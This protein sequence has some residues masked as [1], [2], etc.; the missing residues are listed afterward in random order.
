M[1][2]EH[3]CDVLWQKSLWVPENNVYLTLQFKELKDS[4][5]EMKHDMSSENYLQRITMH[6][7]WTWFYGVRCLFKFHCLVSLNFLTV[8]HQVYCPSPHSYF[9]H[10]TWLNCFLILLQHMNQPHFKCVL[11]QSVLA[12]WQVMCSHSIMRLIHHSSHT[13]HLLSTCSSSEPYRHFCLSRTFCLCLAHFKNIMEKSISLLPILEC[14]NHLATWH[15]RP[16]RTF[17][18]QLPLPSHYNTIIISVFICY[19][20]CFCIFISCA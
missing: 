10:F 17:V 4:V 15:L 20:S 1:A 6:L 12:V 13:V 9:L 18:Y 3:L 11:L 5:T 19:C 8:F 2:L 7:L 16:G 14:A